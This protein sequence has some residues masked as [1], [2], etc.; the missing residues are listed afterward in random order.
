MCPVAAESKNSKPSSKKK[1]NK[2]INTNLE[3]V[4]EENNTKNSQNLPKYFVEHASI[5]INKREV[6]EPHTKWKYPLML[7][8]LPSWA[9]ALDIDT[10][11]DLKHS[12][13]IYPAIKDLLNDWRGNVYFINKSKNISPD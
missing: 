9:V 3:T 2:K 11:E 1:I 13:I 10:E 8:S 12:R 6:I 5:I 4:V 7:Y